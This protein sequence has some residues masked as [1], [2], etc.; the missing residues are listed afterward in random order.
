VQVSVEAK[1]ILTLP[2]AAYLEPKVKDS[3]SE[4]RGKIKKVHPALAR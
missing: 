3:A 2:S 4:R 1:F